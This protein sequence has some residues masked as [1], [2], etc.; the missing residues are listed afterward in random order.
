MIVHEFVF[1]SKQETAYEVRISDWSSDVCPSDHRNGYAQT[2]GD[3]TP[4]C[5]ELAVTHPAPTGHMPMAIG[6][7]VP[8]ERIE[9]AA[10]NIIDALNDLKAD[11]AALAQT[12]SDA[13]PQVSSAA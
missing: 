9:A 13:I 8:V 7:G 3:V 4:T 11:F 5:G 12:Q 1:F 6:V 10:P 2:R